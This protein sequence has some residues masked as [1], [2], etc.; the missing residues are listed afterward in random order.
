[1]FI[2][3]INYFGKILK[4]QFESIIHNPWLKLFTRGVIFISLVF[5]LFLNRLL[6]D[7]EWV[8]VG[9]KWYVRLY[10]LF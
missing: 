8:H 1:M 10:N 7:E 5:E 9:R 6:K 4:E 3:E 2:F